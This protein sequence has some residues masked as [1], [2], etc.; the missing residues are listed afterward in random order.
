[1][2]SCRF[3]L[4]QRRRVISPRWNVRLSTSNVN[5]NSS[6]VTFGNTCV[7]PRNSIEFLKQTGLPG[8][9]GRAT[10]GCENS[11]V[12][13]TM[14][15]NE[16]CAWL[17]TGSAPA[18]S[19]IGPFTNS[20][21]MMKAVIDAVSMPSNERV[22]QDHADDQKQERDADRL[23]NPELCE[24]PAAEMRDLVGRAGDLYGLDTRPSDGVQPELL[25]ALR[26]GSVAP[27]QVVLE[28]T[29]PLEMAK[30]DL[31]GE[32]I[33]RRADRHDDHAG[34]KHHRRQM[35]EID[36]AAE[37]DGECGDISGKMVGELADP[38]D[39]AVEDGQQPMRLGLLD[40]ADRGSQNAG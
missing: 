31:H 34:E 15:R 23:G 24:R 10:S 37:H 21:T 5:G 28:L 8:S 32:V 13:R 12:S 19:S 4:R 3:H 38:V 27:L 9:P 11:D 14:R 17:N 22:A 18:S 40:R 20:I 35:G 2:W 30:P 1:M 36:Q 7:T 16:T 29:N 25:G 39:I 26:D 33:D 6:V